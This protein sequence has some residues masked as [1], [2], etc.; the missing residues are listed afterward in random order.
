MVKH[1][2]YITALV[3]L[4]SCGQEKR[5]ETEIKKDNDK[6]LMLQTI[7]DLEAKTFVDETNLNLELAGDLVKAYFNFTNNYH[8]DERSPEYLFKAGSVAQ[9]MGNYRQA[10]DIF[11][12]VHEGFPNY[13]KRTESIYLMAFIYD[14]N[15]NDRLMAEKIY[16]K[17]IELYPEHYLA[18]DSQARLSTLFMTDEQMIEL[19]KKKNAESDDEANN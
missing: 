7:E 18:Q 11:E 13:E 12:D 1:I 9:G 5:T 6:E 14:N 15:L 19:F 10:I 3:F 17:V 4:V 8:D 2:I 16:E